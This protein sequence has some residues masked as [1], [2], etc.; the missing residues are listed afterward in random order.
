MEPDFFIDH[1][2][3]KRRELLNGRKLPTNSVSSFLA[4]MCCAMD[5]IETG[6]G[7]CCGWIPVS[8]HLPQEQADAGH[9][10][11]FRYEVTVQKGAFL[12]IDFCQFRGGHW[13]EGDTL[14]DSHVTAW[15]KRTAPYQEKEHKRRR[16]HD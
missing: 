16:I 15:R 10:D 6:G 1:I 8:R 11:G 7:D 13:W 12:D 5:A 2:I 3:K 14:V 9:P 4:G